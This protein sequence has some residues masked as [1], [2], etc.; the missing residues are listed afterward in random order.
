MPAIMEDQ[1]DDLNALEEGNDI[2]Q[3]K[4]LMLEEM[5]QEGGLNRVFIK[6]S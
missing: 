5:T 1:V 3:N 6:I 2:M 4:D